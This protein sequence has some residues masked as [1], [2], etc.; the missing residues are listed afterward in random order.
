MPLVKILGC[1]TVTGVLPYSEGS[2]FT[3]PLRNGGYARGVVARAGPEGKVLFGHFF[4]PKLNSL[5]EVNLENIEPEKSILSAIFGDLGLING[6]W[7]IIG[8]MPNWQ[9]SAWFMPDFVRRDPIG[10]RAWRVHRSDVDPSKV[11]SEV[12]IEFHMNLP[13]N[14]TFGSGAVEL[15]LTKLLG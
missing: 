11:E 8:S 14:W 7:R 6:E 9:R 5:D 15:K 1:P 3:V 4:G 10:K 12:P 13:P 2:I